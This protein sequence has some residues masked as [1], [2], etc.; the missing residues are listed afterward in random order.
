MLNGP[1]PN[2]AWTPERREARAKE[3]DATADRL[4]A[5]IANGGMT[6]REMQGWLKCRAW[7]AKLRGQ[8]LTP[9]QAVAELVALG[10]PL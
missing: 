10:L 6:E 3:L 2:A 7:A 9:E 8:R 5:K 4:V 1:D